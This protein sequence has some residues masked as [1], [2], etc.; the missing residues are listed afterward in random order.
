MAG[1]VDLLDGIV[2]VR[3][4]QDR[5]F[6][7]NIFQHL[8]GYSSIFDV[9]IFLWVFD[10]LP[11][12][13]VPLVC[14]ELLGLALF[15]LV[16][17]VLKIPFVDVVKDALFDALINQLLSVYISDWLHGFDH[18]VHEWLGK[19]R[20]IELVVTH[21]SVTYQVYHNVC[22]E[23]LTILS[24]NF[25]NIRDVGHALSIDVENGNPKRF[26]N[27]SA[28]KRGTADHRERNTQA[29]VA[30]HGEL[31]SRSGC[32]GVRTTT[33]PDTEFVVNPT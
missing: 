15:V 33:D 17:E 27:V 10:F 20:L 8:D 14:I 19:H 22:L 30:P 13:R 25:E 32:P 31:Q 3:F 1:C 6:V 5:D 9:P 23:L 24:R 2:E 11:L 16:L 18:A 4:G 21:L 12:L 26:A 28:V 7:S 29:R